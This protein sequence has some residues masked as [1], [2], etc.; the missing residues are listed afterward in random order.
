MSDQ[1]EEMPIEEAVAN[2][3]AAIK[4]FEN[5]EPETQARLRVFLIEIRDNLAQAESRQREL[6]RAKAAGK[7]DSARERKKLRDELIPKWCE[8]KPQAWDGRQSQSQQ[9][10]QVS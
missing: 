7:R 1:E 9:F 3:V 4:D 10:N 6:E 2:I 5:L 8:E